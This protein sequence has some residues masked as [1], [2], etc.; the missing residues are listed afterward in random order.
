M[1]S[2]M[3]SAVL[4]RLA[5]WAVSPIVVMTVTPWYLMQCHTEACTQ[6]LRS[7]RFGQIG[8]RSF[9]EQSLF[10]LGIRIG[11]D[12]YRRHR[13]SGRHERV[14]K[15]DP[16]HLRHLHIDNQTAGFIYRIRRQKFV[17]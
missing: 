10:S 3:T 5:D 4:M 9:F 17:R 15:L 7:N 16:A 8:D 2:T 14:K 13:I 1:G 6:G 12:E 11:R